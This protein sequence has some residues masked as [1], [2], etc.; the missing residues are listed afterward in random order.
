[1]NHEFRR[2]VS[3]LSLGEPE[4]D[5]LYCGELRRWPKGVTLRVTLTQGGNVTLFERLANCGDD[6]QPR[7]LSQQA[8]PLTPAVESFVVDGSATHVVKGGVL[9]RPS[10]A[11]S[12]DSET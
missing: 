6:E 3:L 11:D 4:R 2:R 12:T 7:Q 1:M 8:R 10:A 5:L 9:C